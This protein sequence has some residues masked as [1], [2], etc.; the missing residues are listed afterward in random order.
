MMSIDWRHVLK[1]LRDEAS[2]KDDIEEQ[3]GVSA[4]NVPLN[5]IAKK[6][7]SMRL[8]ER[9]GAGDNKMPL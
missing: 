8:L 7:L 6:S 2:E 1:C 9:Y 5:R 3:G 4:T